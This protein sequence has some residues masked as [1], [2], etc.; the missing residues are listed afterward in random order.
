MNNLLIDRRPQPGVFLEKFVF[1]R[2]QRRYRIKRS[3]L[4]AVGRKIRIPVKFNGGAAKSEH[5][6]MPQT[7][8]VF[9]IHLYRHAFPG[10]F[11]HKRV[12][13]SLKMF[14]IHGFDTDD[15]LVIFAL[16]IG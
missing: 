10:R 13:A 14:D 5:R 15:L 6:A 2:E 16:Q 9:S 1:C 12:R 11:N 8:Y 7:V 3:V 4:S